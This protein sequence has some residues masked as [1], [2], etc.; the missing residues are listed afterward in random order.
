MSP[1]VCILTPNPDDMAFGGRWSEVRDRMAAPLAA[2]GVEV[3]SRSWIEDPEGLKGYDLIL[4]LVTWGYHRDYDLWCAMT[5]AWGFL[6]LP[7]HNHP[8]VL[9]WNADKRYLGRLAEKG[10]PVT[11]TVYVDRVADIDLHELERKLGAETLI[12]K[13]QVSASAYRTLRVK[14]GDELVDAPEG[15]AMVQPYLAHVEDQ[16]E[17][18]LIYIAGRFS[19]AIRKVAR[20]G[21]FR[22]QPEWGGEITAYTPEDDVLWAADKILKAVEEPLF[23]ARVDMVRDDADMP[24][25]MELELIEPDLY[26]GFDPERGAGFARAVREAIEAR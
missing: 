7:I 9:R 4:P 14:P 5:D 10:A 19:H 6:E 3:V 20:P 17:L 25:L 1:T 21:D 26:L 22:V 13:P 23:Y 18:S 16:G 12:V 11:P 15:K 8:G 2:E 24:M